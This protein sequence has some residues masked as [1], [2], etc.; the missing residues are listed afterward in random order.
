M[1]ASSSSWLSAVACASARVKS[2]ASRSNTSSSGAA[3]QVVLV[4]REDGGA[5]LV[6]AAGHGRRRVARLPATRSW[7]PGASRLHAPAPVGATSRRRETERERDAPGQVREV[8]PVAGARVV[9]RRTSAS[10]A[11]VATTE[12]T[13]RSRPRARLPGGERD[14]QRQVV[15]D[16]VPRVEH[17]AQ[18][19]QRARARRARRRG[20]A[21]RPPRSHQSGRDDRAGADDQ[22]PRERAQ[23]GRRPSASPWPAAV[24]SG[25]AGT[26]NGHQ[27]WCGWKSVPCW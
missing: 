10:G 23:P 18:Q 9:G 19:E 3:G 15:V 8:R 13:G 17:A 16:E 26:P 14:D 1:C 24:N 21:P 12:S 5:A 27:I 22:R 2:A 7:A 4:E 6:G 11:A 20:C 25:V